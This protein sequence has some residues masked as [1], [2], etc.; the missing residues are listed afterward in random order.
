[1][2]RI[3]VT[4]ARGQLGSDLVMAL[5]HRFGATRV[6][7]SGR[8][9]PSENSFLYEVLDVTDHNR[10][11]A[12]VDQYQIDTIYHLASLLSARGEHNPDQCWHIN[13]NGLRNVLE[14]ARSHHIKV[15]F[16]SSIAVFGPHTPKLDTPQITVEDPSTM[17]GVT[18]VTGELLCHYYADRWGVDVRSLRLPGIISYSAPPGG[19]TTDFAIEMLKA[20]INHRTYTCFVRPE[21]RLPMMYMPDAIAAILM[22]MQADPATITIR[23]SYNVAAVSFSAAELATEIQNHL[24]DF[25][26]DYQPDFRQAIADSWPSV[27]DDA[28]ARADWGWKPTYDLP[29]I[30]KDMVSKLS[31]TPYPLLH[32][33][34]QPCS[35]PPLQLSNPF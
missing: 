20:A 21:T 34:A 4:G 2:N 29:A 26:C 15:F 10:L 24:P 25:K 16:P 6:I 23:S 31:P 19:G 22:L 28:R 30:V 27:I 33:E 35:P 12:V 32:P 7:E 3:L 5:R 1:M 14:I 17:Y 11:Q 9:A 18:K 8:S 13:I